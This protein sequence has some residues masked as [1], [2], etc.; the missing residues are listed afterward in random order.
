MSIIQDL[1]NPSG[2]KTVSTPNIL[3][4]SVHRDIWVAWDEAAITFGIA[5]SDA[6]VTYDVEGGKPDINFVS[7]ATGDQVRGNFAF[8]RYHG[9]CLKYL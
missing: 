3:D 2:G 5:K 4:S 6:L 1:D 8:E 7:V 9:K